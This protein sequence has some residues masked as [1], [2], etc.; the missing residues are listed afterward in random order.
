MSG[1]TA[2]IDAEKACFEYLIDVTGSRSGQDAFLGDALPAYEMNIWAFQLAGG[3]TQD[4]NYQRPA[5]VSTWLFNAQ[6]MGQFQHRLAA[7][8]FAG[9]IMNNMP[10]YKND[11]NDAGC[12]SPPGRGIAPNVNLFE[13]TEPPTLDSRPLLVDTREDEEITVWMLFMQ[14]RCQFS[15]VQN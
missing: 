6:L 11:D 10:A 2:W 4:W 9:K 7:Q 14:F 15:N 12:G 8:E 1:G 13:M 5:P 3:Q